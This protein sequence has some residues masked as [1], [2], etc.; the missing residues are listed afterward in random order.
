MKL[1]ALRYFFLALVALGSAYLLYCGYNLWNAHQ[2]RRALFIYLTQKSPVLN[3]IP[4]D[5]VAYI[6]LFDFKRVY[7]DLQGTHLSEVLNHWFDTGMAANEKANALRGGMIE[8]TMLN[9]LGDEFAAAL[10]PG[11]Q[12]PVDLVAVAK[13]A[14]GSDFLLN[15]ALAQSH[16]STKT[17]FHDSLIYSFPTK[18][19]DWPEFF[20]SVGDN[21]A[22]ASSDSNRIQQILQGQNC[23]PKFLQQ[24]TV[25]AIPET[26]FL[27]LRASKPQ[28]SAQMYG[29][30]HDY[31]LD[32]Y[33]TT[34]ITGK[35]PE[36]RDSDRE[37]LHFVSNLPCI[38]NAPSTSFSLSANGTQPVSAITMQEASNEGAQKQPLI[39]KIGFQKTPIAG[40]SEKVQS[41]D[42]S[43]FPESAPFYFLSCVRDISGSIDGQARQ[44]KIE[45][46]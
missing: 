2:K 20:V 1:R 32:A 7:E 36:M 39:V 9:I 18:R 40:F 34:P 28:L 31:Y 5:A 14:P 45:I 42:W 30:Q 15:L 23:G 16:H 38:M 10:V 3:R 41:Q 19:T 21:Y 8:K 29:T 44:I 26:T 13:L 33:S 25:E 24:L 6:N 46:E 11:K 4:S 43:I 37:V 17:E 12:N 22:Y 35:L 27:F